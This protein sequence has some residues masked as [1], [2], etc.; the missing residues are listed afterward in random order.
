MSNHADHAFTAFPIILILAAHLGR[1]VQS[2]T[3]RRNNV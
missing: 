3:P 1:R 2:H